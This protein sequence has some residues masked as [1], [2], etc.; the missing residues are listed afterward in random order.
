[1]NSSDIKTLL[2]YQFPVLELWEGREQCCVLTPTHVSG[3][4]HLLLPQV[5]EL[6]N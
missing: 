5:A 6:R 4:L 2:S 1:M 3:F